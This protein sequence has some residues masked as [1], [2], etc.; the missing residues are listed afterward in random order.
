MG[1]CANVYRRGA[2][3]WWRKKARVGASSAFRTLA[4]SLMVREP[5]RA[6][7]LGAILNARF[8]LLGPKL[9]SGELSLE[10]TRAIFADF[11]RHETRRWDDSTFRVVTGQE[12]AFFDGD[13]I[14]LLPVS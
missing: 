1:L 5:A 6:K 13:V 9:M 8:I 4:V 10:Q 12:S 7:M 2:V 3:Y 14:G 11:V